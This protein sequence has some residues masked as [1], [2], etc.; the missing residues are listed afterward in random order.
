[1]VIYVF[2]AVF[3]CLQSF[4]KVDDPLIW[5]NLFWLIIIFGS[6]NAV[7]RGNGTSNRGRGIYMYF[8]AKPG[9]VIMGKMI[10]QA[11]V[12]LV[13]ALITLLFFAIRLGTDPL[14]NINVKLYFTAILLG[15]LGVA[16]IFTLISSMAAKTGNRQGLASILGIPLIIPLLVSLNELCV[17]AL[18]DLPSELAN[19]PILITASVDVLAASL[20]YILFPY[21]WTE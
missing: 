15:S 13:L 11:L 1:V 18:M 17:I 12:I 7:I 2:A 10:Y 5:N 4:R 16:F 8:L 3:L 14:K 9:N 21:I 6:A 20:A 19:E